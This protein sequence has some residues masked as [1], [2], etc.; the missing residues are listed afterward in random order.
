MYKDLSHLSKEQLDEL[1][2]MYYCSYFT[3][4]TLVK[5]YKLDIPYRSLHL[6]FP[7][8]VLE[9]RCN[10]CGS[11]LHLELKRRDFFEKYHHRGIPYCPSCGSVVDVNLVDNI[12]KSD[13]ENIAYDESD[14][15]FENHLIDHILILTKKNRNILR[16]L[17]AEKNLSVSALVSS[18][19]DEKSKA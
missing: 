14:F 11:P 10:F 2:D 8:I 4:I 16:R 15:L 6:H 5:I 18:W 17:A 13:A 19:I 12:D 7:D 3:A 1:L 9:D